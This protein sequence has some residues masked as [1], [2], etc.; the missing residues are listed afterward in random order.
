MKSTGTTA[1]SCRTLPDPTCHFSAL[2]SFLNGWIASSSLVD[3]RWDVRDQGK[4][5]P[6]RGWP[7]FDYD[8]RRCLVMFDFSSYVRWVSNSG[9]R[10]SAFRVKLGH[11]AVV[12]LCQFVLL[13]MLTGFLV[14]VAA[15]LYFMEL[16]L[17]L[18]YPITIFMLHASGRLVIFG[19]GQTRALLISVR[20]CVEPCEVPLAMAEPDGGFEINMRQPFVPYVRS[21]IPGLV[22]ET[23]PLR[24]DLMEE[25]GPSLPQNGE[26]IK[27]SLPENGEETKRDVFTNGEEAKPILP[28][29]GEEAKPILPQ[30]GE[31]TKSGVSQNGEEAKPILPQNGEE[32]KSGVSQNGEETKSDLSKN[33]EETKSDL[34]KNGEETKSSLSQ[35][36]EET[37]SSPSQNDKDSE[38]YFTPTDGTN[39]NHVSVEDSFD[40]PAAE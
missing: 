6:F 28:Q 21:E 40:Q 37:K 24:L 18:V 2:E 13:L 16:T 33:G 23:Y 10:E 5:S 9:W 8:N 15:V 11:H 35:N 30:N 3:V 34:S 29:N 17:N 27:P 12:S 25:P 20:T 39:G 26:E 32:T 22:K 19:A 38:S 7:K 4:V 1:S 14:A 36:G 31:E